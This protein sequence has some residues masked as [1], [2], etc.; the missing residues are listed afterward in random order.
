MGLKR[1]WF[2]VCFV[3]CCF[4][5]FFLTGCFPY[6]FWGKTEKCNNSIFI[7]LVSTYLLAVNFLGT[8]WSWVVSRPW[9]TSHWLIHPL[10]IIKLF[11]KLLILVSR[12]SCN[13]ESH[14]L[15]I[16]QNCSIFCL[17]LAIQSLSPSPP[18]TSLNI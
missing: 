6:Q 8:S 15:F 11:F 3:L 1:L 2:F 5:L 9:C 7:R 14:R 12:T 18:S 17:A 4:V 16:M 10:W 13:K